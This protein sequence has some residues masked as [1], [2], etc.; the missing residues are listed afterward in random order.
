MSEHSTRTD[1]PSTAR[2]SAKV[3][4]LM[5]LLGCGAEQ[6]EQRM[7]DTDKE[8]VIGR[9]VHGLHSL[10]L[11]ADDTVSRE[12]AVIRREGADILLT[13]LGSKNRTFVNGRPLTESG[14]R[15]QDGDVIRVG[16]SLL[17][18]RM[19]GDEED[20]P[21][22]C[23]AVHDR[24][25]GRA[26]VMRKLRYHL[27]CAARTQDPVLLLGPT[28]SG[29]EEATKALHA[30]SGRAGPLVSINSA[31]LQSE[32]AESLLFG[33]RKG[34]FTGATADQLGF[35]RQAHGGTL[36]LDE[37][38]DLPLPLQP[39]LL[40]VLQSAKVHPVGAEHE[41]SVDVRVIA[42]T[43]V[44][45]Q[46]S[47]EHGRFR[48]D[49]YERLAVLPIRLPPLSAR[50][51]DILHLFLR[52]LRDGR[53]GV[54]LRADLAELVLLY[55]WPHNV[56]ELRN[57]ARQL[58]AFSRPDKPLGM[59][60]LPAELIAPLQREAQRRS[61]QTEGGSAELTEEILQ[62]LIKEHRG[63]KARIAA[64][65]GMDVTTLKNRIKRLGLDA[66][67]AAVKKQAARILHKKR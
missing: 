47:V 42:A 49:L 4:L 50:R 48:A 11:A 54:T 39:K 13:D 16:G 35:F 8:L 45:L 17:L 67:V 44:D 65:L 28:G 30:L 57:F 23:R 2:L 18:F 59:D 40:R 53:A 25:L 37:I 10:R 63:V 5:Q 31:A 15:L 56:R 24:L 1:S 41:Q 29:K 33:H 34:S 14:V 58:L 66:E 22:G 64:A 60:S 38:G 21:P 55:S 3:P 43:H 19:Q 9:E 52:F 61:A 6:R 7:V 20:A 32:L 46:Q 51:E 12:H 27:S 26:S 36:F 62:R